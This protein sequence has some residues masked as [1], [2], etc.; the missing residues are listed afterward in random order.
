MNWLTR[1]RVA[2]DLGAVVLDYVAIANG[3][4]FDDKG[5]AITTPNYVWCPQLDD[6]F[7]EGDLERALEAGNLIPHPAYGL[8]FFVISADVAVNQEFPSLSQ[9]ST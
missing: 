9:E 7:V 1:A 6:D 4:L 5:I 2:Q 8:P 3:P